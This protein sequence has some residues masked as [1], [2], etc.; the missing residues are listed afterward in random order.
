MEFAL[1]CVVRDVDLARIVAKG[2]KL[3]LRPP[4]LGLQLSGEIASRGR[5]QKNFELSFQVSLFPREG[6][7]REVRYGSG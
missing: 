7:C 6:R 5:G 4:D 2:E 1:R 3:T